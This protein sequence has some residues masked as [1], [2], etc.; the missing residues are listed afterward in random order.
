VPASRGRQ[1]CEACLAWKRIVVHKIY[2]FMFRSYAHVVHFGTRP[3]YVT[4]LQVLQLSHPSPLRWAFVASSLLA[5]PA[6]PVPQ[7]CPWL[8]KI[9]GQLPSSYAW[10]YTA[11]HSEQYI[12]PTNVSLPHKLTFSCTQ[13]N[14]TRCTVN[15]GHCR[16][17]IVRTDKVC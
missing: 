17:R 11:T 15:H 1:R 10:L 3:C 14:E 16:A 9:V 7:Q 12:S 4:Y 6:R 13:P 8:L 5:A 2:F